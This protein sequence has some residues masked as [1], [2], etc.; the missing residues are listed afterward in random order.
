MRDIKGGVPL[1]DTA[2][3]VNEAFRAERAEQLRAIRDFNDSIPERARAAA[4]QLEKDTQERIA[5]GAMVPV[6]GNRF[7]VTQG[8]DAGEIWTMQQPRG[9]EQP[10]LLPQSGLDLFDDGSAKLYTRVPT[11]HSLEKEPIP[12]GISDIDEV[13]RLG[14]LDFEVVK[15]NA[16][17][18]K[19]VTVD[20][21]GNKVRGGLTRIPDQ[22]VT[23]RADTGEPLNTVGKVYQPIQNRDA[24]LF[25]Q[26]LVENHGVV[27]ESAG[28]LQGGRRVFIGLRLPENVVLDIGDGR[29]DEIVPFVFWRN[30]HDGWS[31]ASVIVTPWRI[32][33]GNTER[34]AVRDALTSW[35]VRHTKSAM[36]RVEEA[37]R[38]LGLTVK[39]FDHFKAEE[40]AL[41]RTDLLV[42]EFEGLLGEVYAKPGAEESDR[43]RKNWDEKAGVLTGMFKTESERLGKTAY[44]AERVFTDY[45][46][47]VAPKRAQ[48]DKLAAA[49]A[50]A[51]VTGT[52]DDV[53]S[54]VHNKLMLK[55]RSR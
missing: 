36:E 9:M 54:K 50:T 47:N 4:E 33:C 53:R 3:D 15:V 7:R 21:D 11:W 42:A 24:G 34:F 8:W 46:D 28:V 49:R 1:A 44:A 55:V 52:D 41:A 27:F 48:G 10:L 35:T 18:N 19:P 30:S 22:F 32:S 16:L 25:L 23:V 29:E 39:H 31:S 17:Y 14:G 26:D 51:L 13:L 45:L 6:G 2:I 5:S 40:E 37:Q 20:K 43:K 38:T 12:A